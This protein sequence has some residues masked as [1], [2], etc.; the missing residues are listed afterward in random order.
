MWPVVDSG[1][2]EEYRIGLFHP[3]VPDTSRL[4]KLRSFEYKV[5]SLETLHS[6]ILSSVQPRTAFMIV[7]KVN[8]RNKFVIRRQNMS[9]FVESVEMT[10]SFIH[11]R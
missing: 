1:P 9:N 7:S 10:L 5:P 8:V 4:I 3:F 11:F 6:E 2:A